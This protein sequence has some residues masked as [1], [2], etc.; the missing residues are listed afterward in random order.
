MVELQGGSLD[1]TIAKAQEGDGRDQ[2][3]AQGQARPAPG[4]MVSWPSFDGRGRTPSCT[5]WRWKLNV[6]VRQKEVEFRNK[7]TGLK[8]EVRRRDDALL[9]EG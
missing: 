1:R 3:G 2:E 8:E 4:P 9:A 6:A 5:I 7:E